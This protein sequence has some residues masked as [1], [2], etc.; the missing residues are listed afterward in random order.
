MEEHSTRWVAIGAEAAFSSRLCT[1]PRGSWA[2]LSTWCRDRASELAAS[3]ELANAN[4]MAGV[5]NRANIVVV[6]L[7]A[8]D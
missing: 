6:D 4:S 1:G 3:S 5:A 8:L 2:L 7:T